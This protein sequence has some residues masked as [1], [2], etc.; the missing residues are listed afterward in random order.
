MDKVTNHDVLKRVAEDRS[1]LN[2]ISQL[3]VNIDGLDMC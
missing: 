2:A 1:I 3:G